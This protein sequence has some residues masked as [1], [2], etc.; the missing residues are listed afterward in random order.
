MRGRTE[1]ELAP[2]PLEPVAVGGSSSKA[3]VVKLVWLV[4]FLLVLA[5]YKPWDTGGRGA[6]LSGYLPVLET[7]SPTPRATTELDVVAG[8]CLQPS[9]WRVYSSERWGGQTVRSWT[10]LT[11]IG[12][13][14]G[15]TDPRIPFVPVVSQVVQAIGFCAPVSGADTPPTDTR[16]QMYRLSDETTT[17][18]GTVTH[19]TEIAPTRVAPPGR[20]SYLGVAYAPPSG[21]GW[22]N[23]LYVVHV[24]GSDYT[25]WFG[26]QV[27]TL[28]LPVGS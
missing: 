24:Q 3:A 17:G 22:P 5:F 14:A 16:S 15:P 7:P 11:P 8:F 23:G 13:A 6:S 25:R 18:G 26:I 1:R 20:A 4:A 19:A 21:P 28:Q 12:A 27:E 10:A 2:G 9:G